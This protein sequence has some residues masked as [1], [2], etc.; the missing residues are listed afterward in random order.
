[1]FR[2]FSINF[3]VFSIFLDGLIVVFALAAANNLRPLLNVLPFA[4]VLYRSSIP[5]VL[6]LVFASVWILIFLLLS[7]YDGRKNLY[8]VDEFASISIGTLLASVSLAGLL[9]FTYRDVSR[10]LFVAFILVAFVLM[11]TWRVLV[12]ISIPT[13]QLHFS[14]KP[15]G[16]DRWRG[17]GWA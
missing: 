1:M 6:Y 14:P 10:L 16:A 4:E 9:Y 13:A 15:Q 7:V 11:I 3:A 12:R 17:T 8:A 2:R 5:G